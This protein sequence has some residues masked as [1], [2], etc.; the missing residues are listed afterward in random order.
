MEF[1]V[2]CLYGARK[3]TETNLVVGARSSRLAKPRKLR[4]YDSRLVLSPASDDRLL[5]RSVIGSVAL[6][7]AVT[8][9]L[10]FSFLCTVLG[11]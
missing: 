2:N 10:G 5:S 3:D 1:P 4:G 6:T 11:V 8:L 7:P 9:H